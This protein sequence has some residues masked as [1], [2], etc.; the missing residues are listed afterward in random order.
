MNWGSTAPYK[1]WIRSW[2]TWGK[3]QLYKPLEETTWETGLDGLGG[4]DFLI[5]LKWVSWSRLGGLWLDVC[6]FLASEAFPVNAGRFRCRVGTWAG[7]LRQPSHEG[8]NTQF[9]FICI[10][11]FWQ[12]QASEN[13]Q[14]DTACCCYWLVAKSCPT[15]FWSHGL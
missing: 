10:V 14:S 2:G 9:T 8:P 12:V 1:Q 7:P 5:R 11:L 6:G 4:W 3:R 13:L 15:L